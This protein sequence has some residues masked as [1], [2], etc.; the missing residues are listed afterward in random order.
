MIANVPRIASTASLRDSPGNSMSTALREEG[1]RIEQARTGHQ[2]LF[3]G[4]P[5]DDVLAVMKALHIERLV[6][7]GHSLAGL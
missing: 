7:V 4:P 3:G 6:P 1:W 5:R 2:Q